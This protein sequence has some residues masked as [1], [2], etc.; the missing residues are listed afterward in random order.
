[1]HPYHGYASENEEIQCVDQYCCWFCRWLWPCWCS[2]PSPQPSQTTGVRTIGVWTPAA[3]TTVAWTI[4]AS[5]TAVWTIGGWT[6]TRRPA[7]PP[8]PPRWAALRP[9]RQTT[10]VWTIE[11]STTA[12]WTIGGWT[13]GGWTIGGWTIG[14]WTTM[15]RPALPPARPRWAAPRPR[16]A[17]PA[18]LRPPRARPPAPLAAPPLPLR[19]SFPP[20]AASPSYLCCRLRFWPC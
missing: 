4:A 7:L 2:R 9:P 8:A 10:G 14:G 5:T 20:P 11:V 13:I 12:V 1:M 19:T 3:P 18:A 17:R 15:R 6:T 16:R